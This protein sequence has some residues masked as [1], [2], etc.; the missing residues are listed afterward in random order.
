MADSQKT[1]EIT[2]K[3][4]SGVKEL[5]GSDK[6][7]AYLRTMSRFYRYSTRNTLLIHLQ[8]PN[9]TRVASYLCYK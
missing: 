8:M 7:A 1:T 3:L 6:Y 9:A 2:Q 5:F 4:E